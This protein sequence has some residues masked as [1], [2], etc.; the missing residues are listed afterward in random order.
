MNT[1]NKLTRFFLIFLGAAA[2]TFT[3]TGC[4]DSAEDE[5]EDAAEE[6]GDAAEEMAD[7]V[8]DATN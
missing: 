3:V 4:E 6:A 2:L 8:E 5:M 1:L 7:E